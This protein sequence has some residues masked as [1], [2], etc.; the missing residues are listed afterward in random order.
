VEAEGRRGGKA[1]G[2]RRGEG[3]EDGGER[4]SILVLRC[5]R[6]GEGVGKGKRF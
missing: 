4:V 3:G 5:T 1:E 6:L 2:R